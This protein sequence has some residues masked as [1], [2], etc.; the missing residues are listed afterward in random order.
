MRAA[1]RQETPRRAYRLGGN[2]DHETITL[3][4]ADAGQIVIIDVIESHSK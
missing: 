4:V 2:H 3:F 1:L